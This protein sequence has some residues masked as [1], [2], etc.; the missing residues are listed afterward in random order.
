MCCTILNVFCSLFV[1][2]KNQLKRIYAKMWQMNV[3]IFESEF[4]NE[5]L[6][7]YFSCTAW[8][9]LWL[10][11]AK[12]PVFN[13][14]T[15]VTKRQQESTDMKKREKKRKETKLLWKSRAKRF[16]EEGDWGGGEE[17]DEIEEAECVGGKW[18]REER[19]SAW[20]VWLNALWLQAASSDGSSVRHQSP[21]SN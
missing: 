16:E 2:E 10:A 5:K 6:Q 3:W 17:E 8:A 12:H 20:T 1:F 18:E 21:V 7:W 4:E 15:M 9:F 13:S 11:C 14:V 19:P